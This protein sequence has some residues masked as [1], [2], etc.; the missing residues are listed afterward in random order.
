MGLPKFF[1]EPKTPQELGRSYE[2]KIAKKTGAYLQPGSGNILGFKE[3][4][5]SKEYLF[6]LKHTKGKQMTI[7]SVDLKQLRSN[8]LKI[9]KKPIFLFHLDGFNYAVTEVSEK[10]F[11]DLK[12]NESS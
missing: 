6:Q 4:L 9:G 1:K 5:I 2:K 12:K 7:K 8:A 10:T 11:R 3:D